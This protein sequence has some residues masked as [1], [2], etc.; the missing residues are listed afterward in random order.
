MIDDDPECGEGFEAAVA[1]AVADELG[2]AA[3]DVVWVRTTFE[4]AIAPGPKTF[5]FNI[6]QFSITDERK[7]TVDF[8][9]AV[10]R[11]E[12]VVVDDRAR[13]PPPRA[14]I[15]DLRRAFCIG[16]MIGTTSSQ[17]IEEV[18]EPTQRAQALQLQR[19]RQGWRSRTV[20]STRSCSTCR[21]RST[22]TGV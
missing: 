16:A 17:T 5:D 19:R 20:R 10:L 2:F 4:E 14:S 15:A 18:I 13:S 12:Q 22:S 1:Y 9:L 21:P 7:E 8:S 3:D 11:D 6:Q